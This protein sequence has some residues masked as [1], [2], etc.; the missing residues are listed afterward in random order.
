MLILVPLF[1]TISETKLEAFLWFWNGKTCY[2]EESTNA[3]LHLYL[4]FLHAS[5]VKTIEVVTH[6]LLMQVHGSHKFQHTHANT[7][8]ST[9]PPLWSVGKRGRQSKRMQY[10]LTA[11]DG[12]TKMRQAWN[13]KTKTLP[14]NLGKQW[15][16][17]EREIVNILKNS[18]ICKYSGFLSIIWPVLNGFVLDSFPFLHFHYNKMKI[19]TK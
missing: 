17:Q 6:K 3:F 9:L 16:S 18:S 14:Q 13:K 7:K 4:W 19:I 10:L 5:T 12:W 8:A 11:T 15:K 2:K 1:I